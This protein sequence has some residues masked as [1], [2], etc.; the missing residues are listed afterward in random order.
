MPKNTK[1]IKQRI[2][3]VKSTKKITRSMQM[4]AAAKM[5]KT[6]KQ[7]QNSKRYSELAYRLLSEVGKAQSVDH[8]LL[9]T[10]PV[11][12]ELLVMMTASRGL[13]GN[14]NANVLAKAREYY[15][16]W[17]S[18][19]ESTVVEDEEG[20]KV[21]PTLKVLAV[22]KKAAAF[23]KKR[24]L[25]LVALYEKLSDNPAYL[26][27][28]PIARTVLQGYKNGEFDKVTIIYTD[29]Q[30]SLLQIVRQQTLLPLDA[31]ALPM[32]T[33]NVTDNVVDN[34]TPADSDSEETE[35]KLEPNNQL[36]LDY[37]LPLLVEVKVYQSTLESAASEHSSRMIAMKN[38]TDNAGEIIS[39]LTL[40]YNKS[41]QSSITQ[42]VAE[43]IAGIEA[44]S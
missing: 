11:K 2:A 43:I 41:R 15:A 36:L 10:R 39:A 9:E 37:I 8:E 33:L 29:Y 5:Q 19:V 16:N 31:S 26:S 12:N 22:G 20:N 32:T 3:S 35:Y 28:L 14:F 24:N 21:K 7:V 44:L 25:D 17:Q 18:T 38:A 42:E 27:V 34:E 40:E 13:C 1:V 4:I 6:V 23:A 30:S